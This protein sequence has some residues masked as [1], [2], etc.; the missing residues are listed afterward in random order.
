MVLKM[1]LKEI[2][3]NIAHHSCYLYYLYR[4]L[5]AITECK[6]LGY[7]F[8]VM[9][10]IIFTSLFCGNALSSADAELTADNNSRNRLIPY[11]NIAAA[12]DWDCN[13]NTEETVRSI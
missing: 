10:I 12:G 8:L 7:T 6:P 13:S 1:V 3:S 5:Y 2:N 11:F 9:A 4:R